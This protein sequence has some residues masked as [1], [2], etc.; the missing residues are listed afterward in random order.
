MKEFDEAK[1]KLLLA[2][3]MAN[4]TM[5]ATITVRMTGCTRKNLDDGMRE[6]WEKIDEIKQEEINEAFLQMIIKMTEN[7]KDF[8]Q[9]MEDQK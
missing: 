9:Y 8:H 6:V 1:F 3:I 7:L 2:H 5:L 4:C